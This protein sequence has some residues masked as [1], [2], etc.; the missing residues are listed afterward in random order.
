[1]NLPAVL[2]ESSNSDSEPRLPCGPR[3]TPRPLSIGVLTYSSQP[4]GSVVCAAQLATA[5]HD[6]GHEVVLYALDK[7][8][9][10]FYREVS[11]PLRLIPA[12]RAPSGAAA[13]VRQRAL[14]IRDYLVLHA[15]HHDVFHCMDCLVT[16]GVLQ[17]KRR[18]IQGQV[19]RTVH[20]V[21]AFDDEYLD[22]CQRR[23]ILDS[24]QLVSVSEATRKAVSAGFGRPSTR[25][26]NGLDLPSLCRPRVATWQAIRARF[27]LQGR[28]VLS[29]GGVE[30]RKNSLRQ[31][32]AFQR[33]LQ[34][35]PHLTWVIA[36]GASLFKR[37]E[38]QAEFEARLAQLPQGSVIRTGVVDDDELCALYQNADALLHAATHEGW[39]LSVLE[40]LALGLPVV[41]SRGAPFDEYLDARCAELV[42]SSDS[43]TI[44]EGLHRAL[45]PSSSRRTAGLRCAQ[46][47]SWVNTA[48]EHTDLYRRA[49]QTSFESKEIVYA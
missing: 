8:E 41:A 46:R 45:I 49:L 37:D 17:A 38:Y 43:T 20:H 12:G 18:G 9:G 27:G 44:A 15:P 14:E 23:S 16:N 25:I 42:E 39:G 24:D 35:K 29:V 10:G 2:T 32:Q 26:Y 30:P 34:T 21:D 31:L 47:F 13:L 28:Y 36:G 6:L 22:A 1:M 7:G 3:A 19:V 40:G 48:R 5:L 4:R 11:C 33:V